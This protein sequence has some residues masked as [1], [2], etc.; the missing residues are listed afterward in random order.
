MAND[1]RSVQFDKFAQAVVTVNNAAIQVVQ[2]ASCEPTTR[3]G[4][5]RAKIWRD[6]RDNH[7]DQVDRFNASTF[8]AFKHFEA[9]H[10]ALLLLAFGSF[11]FFAKFGNHSLQVDFVKQTLNSGRTHLDFD[12]IFIFFRQVAIGLFGNNRALVQAFER[13]FASIVVKFESFELLS[14]FISKSFHISVRIFSH[15]FV[16][17]ANSFAG[18]NSISFQVSETLGD[19]F[20]L[21][22]NNQV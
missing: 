12:Q 20:I 13:S 14:L 1:S 2:I 22:A 15:L 8:H 17:Q 18:G 3:K 10:K 7:E 6:D 9:L 11:G 21:R 19:L 16:A 4:D 5:H